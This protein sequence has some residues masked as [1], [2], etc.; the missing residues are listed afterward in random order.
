MPISTIPAASIRVYA[1][2]PP[3]EGAGLQVPCV[4]KEFDAVHEAV[5]FG[6]AFLG[7]QIR[8]AGIVL[9]VRC[10]QAKV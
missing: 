7:C 10:Y 6:L 5:D 1:G 4:S 9:K 3:A 8:D 2:K